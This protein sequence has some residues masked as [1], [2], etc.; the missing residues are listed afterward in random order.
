MHAIAP[1]ML[2][3][4]PHASKSLGGQISAS[5]DNCMHEYR[6]ACICGVSSASFLP[7]WGTWVGAGAKKPRRRAPAAADAAAA[8]TAAAAAAAANRLVVLNNKDD[9][10][11][12]KYFVSQVNPKPPTLI[13]KSRIALSPLSP[14][15]S[16]CCSSSTH[17]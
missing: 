6:A 8:A 5:R 13:L 15:V 10:K 1:R 17:V 16:A 7:G 4:L 2:A 11:S 12:S 9:K 3:L 14:P